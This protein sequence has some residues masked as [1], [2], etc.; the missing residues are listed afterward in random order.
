M[1][2]A[3]T[4]SA[5][6]ILAVLSVNVAAFG[7][8]AV[9]VQVALDKP[10]KLDLNEVPIGQVFQK[11]TQASG[12]Q[13]VIDHEAYDLLPY[14]DQTRLVVNIPNITLR[15]A[16]LADGPAARHGMGHR[17]ERRADYADPAAGTPNPPRDV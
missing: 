9:N 12:V 3:V 6:L 1:S 2:K 10:V 15:N 16:G 4:A 13:F 8:P 14:G 5:V 11:L 17:E 7:Q